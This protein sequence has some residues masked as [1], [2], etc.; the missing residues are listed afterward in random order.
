MGEFD[1]NGRVYQGVHQP[2]VS[3]ELWER[4]Q[5]VLE[6]RHAKRHR[7]AKPYGGWRQAQI[8]NGC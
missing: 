7:R 3:R 2:I 6:G 4:V 8:S 5:E 1:W